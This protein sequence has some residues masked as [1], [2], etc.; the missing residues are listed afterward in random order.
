MTENQKRHQ[1]LSCK[2]KVKKNENKEN[3]ELV[4]ELI[5][6]VPQEEE[7]QQQQKQS[8]IKTKKKLPLVELNKI[9]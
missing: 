5:N 7:E 1:P 4:T 6:N 3:N 2:L 9:N 8:K